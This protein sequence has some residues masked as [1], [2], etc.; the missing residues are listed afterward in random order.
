MPLSG[1]SSIPHPPPAP[2]KPNVTAP[3]SIKR[4][5]APQRQS[6][7]EV[8]RDHGVKKFAI[9]DQNPRLRHILFLA[10]GESEGR[11]PVT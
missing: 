6:G 2:P 7:G 9:L 11:G 8:G 5:V 4:H 3:A 1:N 10:Q